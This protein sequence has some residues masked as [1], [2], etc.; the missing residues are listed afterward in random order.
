VDAVARVASKFRPLVFG[1]AYKVLDFVAEMAMRINGAPCRPDGRWT[2]KEKT[3]FFL[4][5][6]AQ[7]A[8]RPLDVAADYWLRTARLYEVLSEHRHAVVH[9]RTHTDANGDLGGTD[10]S[11][12]P[13]RPVRV[14]EQD[15]L[16]RYAATLAAAIIETAANKRVLRVLAWNLDLLAPHHGC[17]SLGASQPAAAPLK[18]LANLELGSSGCWKL[19]GDHLHA[20]LREQRVD[21]LDA[22]A[23]LYAVRGSSQS[24]SAYQAHHGRRTRRH[25]R[26][27]SRR[28]PAV[29]SPGVSRHSFQPKRTR[30]TRRLISSVT[31]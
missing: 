28:A 13:L 10:S 24:G 20:H 3:R 15:A 14:A 5:M 30:A 27:R 1:A 29:A 16:S 6:P 31:A 22:D 9:R 21:P 12:A 26:G 17:G 18:V 8:P 4:N 25:C 19:R 7:R 23:E 2:F 11:G